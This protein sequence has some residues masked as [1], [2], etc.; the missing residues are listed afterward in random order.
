MG[1][2]RSLRRK[3]IRES[4]ERLKAQ[5]KAAMPGQQVII[6]GPQGEKMSE[7]LLDFAQPYLDL[8]HDDEAK[9]KAIGL[10]ALSW[11]VALMPP[12]K[13]EAEIEKIV[14][15]FPEAAEDMRAV[16]REMIQR[17]LILF[18]AL[19]RTVLSYEVADL[20]GGQMHLSV[21]STP[22]QRTD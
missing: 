16:M 13:H 22:S 19:N 10:A 21:M 15:D 20:G 11:N 2:L 7:V 14:G 6:Q 4:R 1:T 5:A 18:P 8:A 17:K 3:K 9:R 12:E